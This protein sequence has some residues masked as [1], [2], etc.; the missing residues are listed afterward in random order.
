MRTRETAHRI[1]QNNT[2]NTLHMQLNEYMAQ[3]HGATPRGHTPPPK[4]KKKKIHKKKKIKNN[5]AT[6]KTT[7]PEEEEED[8]T[9][10][11]S[12]NKI[13]TK[14]SKS[15][16]TTKKKTTPQ[17]HTHKRRTKKKKNIRQQHHTSD[18]AARGPGSS[19]DPGAGRDRSGLG[20][21]TPRW[22]DANED[23]EFC[24]ALR[25]A[26]LQGSLARCYAGN[27]VVA[28][29]D[30]AAEF[31]ETEVKLEPCCPCSRPRGASRERSG[32]SATRDG[33]PDRSWSSTPA[34]R[35]VRT[36]MSVQGRGSASRV[37]SSWEG[38]GALERR[39]YRCAARSKSRPV[40]VA[41]CG[42]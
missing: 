30:P 11:G 7:T 28:D 3:K 27:G 14:S 13:K 8:V 41:T 32:A 15:H 42:S 37:C 5:M 23:G 6:H 25:C 24:V 19:P 2:A 33:R 38:A 39:P 16:T 9:T 22:T 12:N 17:S 26:L 4:K 36:S 29:S 34:G 31:A 40:G 21:G 1:A 10:T 35:S 18:R 20:R